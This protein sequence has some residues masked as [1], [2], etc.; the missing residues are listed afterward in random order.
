MIANVLGH[1][2]VLAV[3][4]GD[5]L[6]LNAERLHGDMGL[7]RGAFFRRELLRLDVKHSGFAIVGPCSVLLVVLEEE[8]L[9]IDAERENHA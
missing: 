7:R 4:G 9:P 1:N 2:L 3:P 5:V 6:H 8:N